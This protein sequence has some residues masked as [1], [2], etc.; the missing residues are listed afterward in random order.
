VGEI[1]NKKRRIGDEVGGEKNRPPKLGRLGSQKRKAD[2]QESDKRI[3]QTS[4]TSRARPLGP[5]EGT[6]GHI[7]EGGTS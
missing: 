6:M 3:R 7:C 4:V 1:G 2:T 5:G